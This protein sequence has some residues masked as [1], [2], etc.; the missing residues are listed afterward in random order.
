MVLLEAVTLFLHFYSNYILLQSIKLQANGIK[1]KKQRWNFCCH[2]LRRTDAELGKA[3][4]GKQ[5]VLEL[6]EKV[7]MLY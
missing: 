4:C 1:K 2:P 7:V 5:Q 3:K 6:W